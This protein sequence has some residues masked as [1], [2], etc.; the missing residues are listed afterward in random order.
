M[1]IRRRLV[2]LAVV[3][4]TA[5]MTLFAILLSGLLARGVAT[6]QD[7]V[8]ARSAAGTAA[9]VAA[10]G[11]DAL[12]S[13]LPLAPVDLV[14][15]VDPFVL[16]LDADGHPLYS[17]GVLADGQPPRI[18]AAV[19]V[20]AVETG[21]SVATIGLPPAEFRVVAAPWS[22]GGET[23]IALAGQSTHFIEQQIAGVRFFLIF[24]AIVTIIAVA[25]VSWFVVG[26]ALRPLRTLTATADEIARTGDLSRRLPAVR[27]KDEV[28]VLTASFNGMLERLS[29]AQE[30]LAAS[31]AAQRRFVA[32]ASHELRTPLTTIRNNAGFL[33][34]HPDAATA[35]RSEAVADIEAESERLSRL[36]DDLLRLARADSGGRLERVPVDL[37][38][39]VEDVARRARRSDRPVVVASSGGGG[40]A[41]VAGD[42]DSL[43]RLVWILVDNAMRHGA[44]DVE[45]TID[46]EGDDVVLR[47]ADRGPG[48]PPGD[49]ERI[50]E[51]FH[52]ADPARSGGGAGLGLAIAATIVAAH[53]GAI[54]AADRE[55]GGAVFRVVLPRL[56]A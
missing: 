41:I 55:G 50:F 49:E 24:A 17:T 31:L 20:E 4:A 14:T 46:A 7:A 32:D 47:V 13:R 15:S 40:S 34:E 43:A 8:L 12:A 51:R 33:V 16:V 54:T 52:R 37:R 27:T 28:G 56:S 11:P 44:G 29:V 23:G 38:G 45:L 10:T 5:G 39:I 22:H 6:D 26:R 18:P 42:A 1:R 3:V 48:I 19:V 25:L 53:D 2:L 30:G 9:V 36:V 35:D 21:S